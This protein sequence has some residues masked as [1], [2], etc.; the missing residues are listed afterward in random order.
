[1]LYSKVVSKALKHEVA[2]PVKVS[3]ALAFSGEA[4]IAKDMFKG[5]RQCEGENGYWAVNREAEENI[6]PS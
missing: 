3:G 4:G 1:M 6:S 5:R 2:N